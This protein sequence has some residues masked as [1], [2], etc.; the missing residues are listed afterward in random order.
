MPEG[1]R[2]LLARRVESLKLEARRVLE[3]ASVVGRVFTAAA[4]AAGVQTPV[5]HIEEVCEGLATPHH[6]LEDIGLT[7]W[8]DGTSTGSYRFRHALYQWVLYEGLGAA[9]RAQ[10]HRRIG[11]RLEA[12]YGTRAREITAQLAVHFERGGE[13]EKAVHAWQQAG[14]QAARRNAQYEAISALRRGLALL[15]T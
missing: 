15:E 1:L 5:E 3:A 7:T 12:G 10:L 14:E 9:R 11:A 8:V 6:F 4:V 2:Q 13:V